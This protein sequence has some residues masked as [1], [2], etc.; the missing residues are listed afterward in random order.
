VETRDEPPNLP[1]SLPMAGDTNG[2]ERADAARNRRRIL[3]VA[4]RLFADRGAENVS[5]D[6]IACAAG[7]GKGTLFR[8]FGDRSGLAWAVLSSHEAAFQE[9]II[10]GGPPLGPGAPASDRLVAFGR[11]MLGLI[12]AHSDLLLAA[13][14]GAPRRR[15]RGGPYASY[16]LYVRSLLRDAAPRLDP[17]YA[18]DALLATLSAEFVAHL[19]EDQHMTLGQIADGY[20]NLVR[21]LLH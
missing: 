6:E 4:E 15:Y 1:M 2:R 18:A 20:E 9:A 13:E 14:C 21:T 11:G 19:R 8:R 3:E 5:M 16:R 17:D 7:V 10:R 12:D